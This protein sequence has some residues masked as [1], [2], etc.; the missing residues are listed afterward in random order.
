MGDGVP[1][2]RMR[3]GTGISGM[4]TD[5]TKYFFNQPIYLLAI[6]GG[7]IYWLVERY[8]ACFV[9]SVTQISPPA[10][11]PKNGNLRARP[12][13]GRGRYQ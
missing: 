12:N 9:L 11:E 3:Q 7:V 2:L 5:A 13:M 1:K 4:I 6:Q 10:T 8:G